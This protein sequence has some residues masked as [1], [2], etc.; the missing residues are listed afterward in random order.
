MWLVFKLR[1][2]SEIGKLGKS[3]PVERDVVD[4]IFSGS[5]S[6]NPFWGRRSVF[7]LIQSRSAWS[8]LKIKFFTNSSFDCDICPDPSGW[9]NNSFQKWM[10]F[11]K[12]TTVVS[13]HRYYIKK[14][15]AFLLADIFNQQ[16]SSILY[17]YSLSNRETITLKLLHNSFELRCIVLLNKIFNSRWF[18]ACLRFSSCPF[19][20]TKLWV[21]LL[22]RREMSLQEKAITVI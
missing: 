16:Y 11:Y 2:C 15:T 12:C 8:N 21:P 6:V 4:R 14:I 19:I 5:C 17:L 18:P 13:A 20:L 3:C 22:F 9:L 7:W 10:L 1:M